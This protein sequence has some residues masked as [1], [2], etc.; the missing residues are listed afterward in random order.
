MQRY[1]NPYL[2]K[3]KRGFHALP[4]EKIHLNLLATQI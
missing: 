4:K 3:A 2:T 1:E